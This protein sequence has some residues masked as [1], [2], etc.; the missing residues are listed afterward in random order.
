MN[1][2]AVITGATGGIGEAL[3]SALAKEGFSLL[4]TGRR[5]DKLLDL[6]KTLSSQFS[7]NVYT[8][9]ADLTQTADR[10][11]LAES[12][13]TKA[14]PLKL[15]IN[16]AGLSQFGMFT[17][18]QPETIEELILAN[19]TAPI[20]LTQAVLQHLGPESK[21]LDI[22]NIGSTFGVIGYPGFT[23][24]SATKFALRGF[25]QALA[26]ELGDTNIRV[27][28]FA[29]RATQTALNSSAVNALN[30]E[31]GTTV[32]SPEIVAEKFLAFLKTNKMIEHIG[33]PE[34]FFVWLNKR[35]PGTVGSALIKQ[36]PIIRRHAQCDTPD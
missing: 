28:Y 14:E 27:R 21:G 23:A 3:A 25:S 19:V 22:I 4:L 5:A 30:S 1:Q 13:V 26:R 2:L 24:Y 15:L 20:C 32:D 6:Q 29:P 12:I 7:I 36:L 34:R 31:L 18:C 35:A 9:V 17:E 10:T 11:A 16:N 33:W 8:A